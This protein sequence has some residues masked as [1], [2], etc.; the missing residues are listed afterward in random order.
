MPKDTEGGVSAWTRPPN[1]GCA[2]PTHLRGEEAALCDEFF[3]E[4]R[5]R[6]C[7][8]FLETGC[9]TEGGAGSVTHQ[10]HRGARSVLE[11]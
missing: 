4:V 5:D 1:W 6:A 8:M 3:F 11:G 10:G 9:A 7:N 2:K